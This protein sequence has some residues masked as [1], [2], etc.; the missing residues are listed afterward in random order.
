M[1][2]EPVAT[3]STS[4]GAA[5]GAAMLAGVGLGW[6]ESVEE[7]CRELV[8]LGDVDRVR[9]ADPAVYEDAYARYRALYPALAPTF[10]SLA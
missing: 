3:T 6:F 7:A 2:Q 1:L 10:H 4:E 8:K 5:Q 9:L